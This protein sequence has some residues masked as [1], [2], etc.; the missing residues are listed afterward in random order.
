LISGTQ[1]QY[2]QEVFDQFKVRTADF[3]SDGFIRESTQTLVHGPDEETKNKL[4]EYLR[5]NKVPLDPSLF[6]IEVFDPQG[7]LLATTGSDQAVS[8][9]ISRQKLEASPVGTAILSR[10]ITHESFRGS[11]PVLVAMTAI[12]DRQTNQRLGY[13]ANHYFIDS[14]SQILREEKEHY[15]SV[16]WMENVGVKSCRFSRNDAC[17]V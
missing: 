8:L 17:C 10:Y 12:I 9:D 4:V 3:S 6:L 16:F 7:I 5:K 2:L 14:L 13:I 11:V 1:S 15:S